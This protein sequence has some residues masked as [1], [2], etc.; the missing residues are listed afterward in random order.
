MTGQRCAMRVNKSRRIE[1]SN[2]KIECLIKWYIAG[3]ANT[4]DDRPT[5]GKVVGEFLTITL[6]DDR[7]VKGAITETGFGFIFISHGVSTKIA[8]SEEAFEAAVKIVNQ[9]KQPNNRET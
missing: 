9:L 5:S 2:S 6:D 4:R 7:E 3:V 1:M 8:L